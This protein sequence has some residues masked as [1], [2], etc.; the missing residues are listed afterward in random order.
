MTGIDAENG[1]AY[2]DN[3]NEPRMMGINGCTVVRPRRAK[4]TT[5]S[6]AVQETVVSEVL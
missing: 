6:A 5:Y 2:V 3:A 4:T 1:R